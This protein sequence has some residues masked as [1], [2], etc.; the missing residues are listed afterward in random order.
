MSKLERLLTAAADCLEVGRNA[1]EGLPCFLSQ[2]GEEYVV[3]T[4]GGRK[5]EDQDYAAT[6]ESPEMAIMCWLY[7]AQQFCSE[8]SGTIYWRTRPEI[9]DAP[10]LSG[11]HIYSRLL[12]SDKPV[13]YSGF[14]KDGL[15]PVYDYRWANAEKLQDTVNAGWTLVQPLEERKVGTTGFGTPQYAYR[16]K[17]PK[18]QQAE[19]VKAAAARAIDR[20]AESLSQDAREAFREMW[21][22]GKGFSPPSWAFK[23]TGISFASTAGRSAAAK[24]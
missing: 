13:L 8:R 15:I 3:I 22:S 7:F 12:I 4:D 20:A 17:K 18:A 10:D 14:T 6:H 2:T 16:Y 11:I 1:V 23:H 21:R 24:D 5:R 9:V 19:D